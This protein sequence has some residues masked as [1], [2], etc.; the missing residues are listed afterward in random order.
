MSDDVDLLTAPPDVT[1]YRVSHRTAYRYTQPMARGNTV[2]HLAPRDTP[3]QR[4]V[5]AEIVVDPAP[6]ERDEWADVFGNRV[7]QFA[8]HHPHDVMTIASTCVVETGAMVRPEC[9]LTWE[10]VAAWSDPTV[11][12]FRAPSPLATA[13]G[14][15]RDL[16]QLVATAFLPGRNIVEAVDDARGGDLP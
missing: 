8:I 2:A 16:E 10:Q 15:G 9:E 14:A 7:L 4:V 6:D 1:R 3:W 11:D 5:D 12:A 13:N